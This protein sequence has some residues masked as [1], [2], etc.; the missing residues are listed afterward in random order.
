MFIICYEYIDI[1]AKLGKTI[2]LNIKSKFIM[3]SVIKNNVNVL[4]FDLDEC[5]AYFFMFMSGMFF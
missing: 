5:L 3:F 4:T 2:Y 1:L